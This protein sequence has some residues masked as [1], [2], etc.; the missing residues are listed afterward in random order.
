MCFVNIRE[1]YEKD[2]KTLPG[3][4]VSSHYHACIEHIILIVNQGISLSIEQYSALIKSIPAI[5]ATLTEMG[6]VIND[7][8]DEPSVPKVKAKKEKSKPSKSN[9]E[10]TSDEES[11]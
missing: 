10:A 1:Y 5:T 7:E 11:D 6:Y 3:K 8:D 2:G 4:K 9:I